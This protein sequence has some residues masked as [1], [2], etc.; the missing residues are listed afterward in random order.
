MKKLYGAVFLNK[1]SHC[2]KYR[3]YSGIND[4]GNFKL[5]RWKR[6]RILSL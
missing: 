2:E 5:E 6:Q 3:Y 4:T 1:K